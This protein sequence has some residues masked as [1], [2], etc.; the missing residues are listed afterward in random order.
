M[1]GKERREMDQRGKNMITIMRQD[2]KMTWMLMP[3]QRMYM[4][5]PMDNQRLGYRPLIAQSNG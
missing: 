1:P 5:M 2:K 4:E 3:E